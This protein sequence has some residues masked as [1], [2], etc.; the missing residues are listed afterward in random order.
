MLRPES[1]GTVHINSADALTP[2]TIQPN[3]LTSQRDC[4]V[5]LE[6][7]KVTRRIAE[8]EPMRSFIVDEHMPGFKVRGDDELIDYLRKFGGISFHPVATCRMGIDDDAVVDER[9]RVRGFTGLRVVD[10]SIMPTVP[11]GNTNAPTIMIAEKASD[12]ILDDAR[13]GVH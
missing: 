13:R 11:S 5:L 7:F 2:P 1:K 10:A 8:S 12:M 4:E 9:L 3:Y 6:G